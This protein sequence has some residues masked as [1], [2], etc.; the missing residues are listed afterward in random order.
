MCTG[1]VP[2]GVANHN[3]PTAPRQPPPPFRPFL[4]L[5]AMGRAITH[6]GGSYMIHAF[7]DTAH[8]LR[9]GNDRQGATKGGHELSP[10]AHARKTLCGGGKAQGPQG[11]ATVG[12]HLQVATPGFLVAPRGGAPAGAEQAKREGVAA[13]GNGSKFTPPSQGCGVQR[14]RRLVA[15]PKEACP[16]PPATQ[17]SRQSSTASSP[18]FSIRR[19]PAPP[20]PCAPPW[21]ASAGT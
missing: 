21:S 5:P 11:P 6:L 13:D 19:L 4:M 8:P 10:K 12:V 18:P 17:A 16:L 15:A 2:P 1:P 7:N 14:D 20:C 3:D 9:T